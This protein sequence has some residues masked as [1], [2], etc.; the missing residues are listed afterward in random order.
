MLSRRV[1]SSHFM[2]AYKQISQSSAQFTEYFQL[3]SP[4]LHMQKLTQFLKPAGSRGVIRCAGG[5]ER[6]AWTWRTRWV[7]NG[8]RKRKLR[9]STTQFLTTENE[10]E[11][12]SVANEANQPALLSYKWQQQQQQ[13]QF[14]LT[15]LER[16][17]HLL[18]RP[19]LKIGMMFRLSPNIICNT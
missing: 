3:P 19:D 16:V 17:C 8:E 7:R 11:L 12:D 14:M 5:A 4:I 2:D 15:P 6:G 1:R 13:L 18:R 9:Y 10:F